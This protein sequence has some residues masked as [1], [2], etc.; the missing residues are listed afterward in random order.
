MTTMTSWCLWLLLVATTTTTTTMT[1]ALAF[2]IAP[3]VVRKV[4]SPW[5][6]PLDKKKIAVLGAGGYLGAYAFGYIQR[7][8]SLYGTGL[9]GVSSPR[10]VAATAMGSLAVN[11][12]L[13]GPFCLAYCG[14]DQVRLANTQDINNLSR[15]LAGMNGLVLGTTCYLERRPV[16]FGTY[17]T[18]PNSKTLELYLDQPRRMDDRNVVDDPDG[19]RNWQIFANTLEAC[20]SSESM[21]HVLVLETPHTRNPSQY[22]DLLE[23]KSSQEDSFSYTYVR[24]EGELVTWPEPGHSYMKGV[25]GDLSVQAMSLEQ[26]QS[27]QEAPSDD[28]KTKKYQP[29]FREDVGAF[30]CQALQS[31]DWTKSRILSVRCNGPLQQDYSANVPLDR[32]WCVNSESLAMALQHLD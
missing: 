12:V 9:G 5:L 31:L 17:E 6:V 11:K 21:Q 23:Q 14:E 27:Q 10:V 2:K 30:L 22:L 7:A 3:N 18:G 13:G 20:Q 16:T 4:G 19:G 15:Q 25:L 26:A 8:S 29:I 32:Q 24:L 1:D 28:Y